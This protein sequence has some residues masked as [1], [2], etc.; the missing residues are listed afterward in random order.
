MYYND[1]NEH[2]DSDHETDDNEYN[3]TVENEKHFDKYFDEVEKTYQELKDYVHYRAENK[4]LLQNLQNYMFLEPI[5]EQTEYKY[6][7]TFNQKIEII[8]KFE[9][10]DNIFISDPI[11]ILEMYNENEKNK[12]KEEWNVLKPKKS[13]ALIEA[14]K[15]QQKRKERIEKR[16]EKQRNEDMKKR[17]YNIMKRYGF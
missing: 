10:K 3:E 6:S 7:E 15:R 13:K 9:N 8:K 12:E 5:F 14:V 11:D 4:E 2:Y 17:T 1:I 16:K